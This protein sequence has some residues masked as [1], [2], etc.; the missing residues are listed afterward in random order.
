MK[1]IYQIFFTS[2]FVLFFTSAIIACQCIINS[3]KRDFRKAKNIFIGEVTEVN[4]QSTIQLPEQIK[5]FQ[6]EI[7][8]TV[9]LNIEKSWKG[10]EKTNIKI[11][12]LSFPSSCGGFQF[13]KGKKY[14]VYVFKENGYLYTVTSC[15]RT[16]IAETDNKDKLEEIKE[17]DS[18]WFRFSAKFNPFN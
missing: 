8:E 5:D 12:S 15:G 2:I 7:V 6:A 11:W 4:Y 9:S 17:L 1:K 18:F 10:K 13:A 3:H 14:L 16:R